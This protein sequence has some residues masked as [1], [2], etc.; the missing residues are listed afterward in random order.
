M[1]AVVDLYSEAMKKYGPFGVALLAL[2]FAGV[3]YVQAQTKLLE[4]QA[5][6]VQLASEQTATVQTGAE[7]EEELERAIRSLER[8]DELVVQEM[9]RRFSFID[10]RLQ[11]V[12][13]KI[14]RQVLGVDAPAGSADTA[15]VTPQLEEAEMPE[16]WRRRP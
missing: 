1:S 5:E 15:P 7:F 13:T 3:S 11:W 2:V 6:Q 14:S 16:V 9:D 4:L 10:Q 8:N 12:E